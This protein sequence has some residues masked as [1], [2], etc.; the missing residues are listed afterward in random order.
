[1]LKLISSSSQSRRHFTRS[2]YSSLFTRRLQ[3]QSAPSSPSNSERH[4]TSR[5]LPSKSSS[6]YL[7]NR[8]REVKDP[9]RS[10]LPL[11][12]QW[13]AEGRPLNHSSLANIVGTMKKLNRWN[14]ALQIS[15]WM[16][17]R[18]FFVLTPKDVGERLELLARVHGVEH[19]EKYFNNLADSLKTYYA[20]G[21]MLKTYV[22]Q[23]DV[24]KAEGLVQKMKELGMTNHSFSYNHMILL[25]TRFNMLDKVDQLVEEMEANGIP[26]DIF[27]KT[28]LLSA[29]GVS[30]IR[31]MEELLNDIKEN[32]NLATKWQFYS[33]AAKFYIKAGAVDKAFEMLKEVEGK[34]SP[35]GNRFAAQHLLT[36][37]A[38]AGSKDDVYRVWNQNKPSDRKLNEFVSCMIS[39][40]SKLDDIEGA[41]EIFKEWESKCDSYDF[42]VVNKLVDAYCKKDLVDKARSLV[43]EKVAEGKET[44]ASTW[45]I[46]AIGYIKQRRMP[47]ATGM[48]KKALNMGRQGWRPRSLSDVDACLDY[49][50][51]HAD[52]EGLEEI[53]GLLRASGLLTLG[54]Y[55]RLLRASIAAGKCLPSIL[56][57]ME[58][59][60][61]HIDEETQKI[62]DTKN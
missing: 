56:A 61:F 4:E 21:A 52:V 11:L 62:L 48:L 36:Y 50:E 18:R 17:D 19:A 24:E 12:E 33:I 40:L 9:K 10:V 35:R 16:T 46:L 25:Y 37:Y 41:E 13:A 49:L 59:D 38:E 58:S 57:Q 5:P 54:T 47:E 51:E 2:I 42:R 22:Q 32:Q 55:H 60:G 15:Q 31:K 28:N 44:Y 7:F 14:H 26:Q 53:I 43:E 34:I 6:D 30:D 39:S 29:Y 27:T 3:S 45:Y 1:M 20:Y 23:K 8:L